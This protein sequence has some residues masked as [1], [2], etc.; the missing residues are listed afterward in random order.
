MYVC[1]GVLGS[2]AA[3]DLECHCYG[4]GQS[5]GVGLTPDPGTSMS[6]AKKKKKK[7]R[8][9][10]KK[11]RM[12]TGTMKMKGGNFSNDDKHES[13]ERSKRQGKSETRIHV[14]S[15]SFQESRNDATSRRTDWNFPT[16]RK[17]YKYFPLTM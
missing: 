17:R 13:H 1:G 6:V 15:Q 3:K 8:K 7:K 9:E 11:N 14:E 4:S 5:Y 12:D 16:H 10:K 2:L